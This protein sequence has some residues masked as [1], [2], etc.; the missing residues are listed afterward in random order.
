MQ[1]EWDEKKNKLNY[2]KHGIYFDEAKEIF[3][4][5]VLINKDTRFDYGEARFIAIGELSGVLVIV[6]IYTNRNENIRIISARKA[7]NKEREKYYEYI[8][9]KI[10]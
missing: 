7:S 4:S 10:K 5:F 3:S 1:F 9:K 8:K 2:E 6:V